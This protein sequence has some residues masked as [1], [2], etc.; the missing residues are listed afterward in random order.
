MTIESTKTYG[1]ERQAAVYIAGLGGQKPA[2]PISVEGLERAASKHL[3]PEAF[4]Y[5][6]GGAGGG[7]TVRA[8]LEAFHRWRLVP[9][10]LRDVSGRS[11]ATTVLGMDLP[12]PFMLA[13]IGVQSIAHAD[14]E[15]AAARAAASLGLPFVTSTA[16]SRTLEDVAAAVGETPHVFQLYWGRNPELTASL[17][18]RAEAAGYGAVLVTLDTSILGWRE[19]DI[20]HAYLPFLQGEGLA[21]Y[22]SDPVFRA[23]LVKPPEEDLLGAVAY[24]VT[25]FTN[26]TLTWDD[27]AF[28]REHTRLP[29]VLK[30]ILHPEDARAAVEHGAHGVVVSNHGGR[31]VDGAIAALDALPAVAEAVAGRATIL[32]D[33]GIRRGADVLKA[34]ALGADAVLLGRPY[35][36][37]LALGGEGGVRDVLDNFLADLDLALALSGHTS[38]RALGPGDLVPAPHS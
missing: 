14:A 25:I 23:A 36:Y 11:L 4:G 10:M 9:R 20:Q 21:N 1:S 24:F 33:S 29:L 8:N 7:A 22:F 28:L 27:V 26:P 13:P 17:L 35:I 2:L 34:I 12:A 37:G 16:A 18:A 38:P 6:A 30:G 19:D 31:Q 3:S 15:V 32:F 5:I